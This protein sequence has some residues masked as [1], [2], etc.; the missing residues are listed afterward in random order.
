[1]R[2]PQRIALAAWVA[3]TWLSVMAAPAQ[4][5]FAAGLAA[6]DAGNF[7]EAFVEWWPL[8]ES[9]DSTAQIAIAELY[10]TGKGV[11]ADVAEAM[12][13]YLLAAEAG[14]AVAQLNL[15]DAYARGLGVAADPIEAYVWFSLAAAQGRQ[16]PAMRRREIADT[17]SPAQLTEA[18][19]RLANWRRTMRP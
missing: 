14:D 12:R 16:W 19:V 15:G 7:R 8:A 4:A 17:L 9:G 10:R 2:P 6:Y 1:M 13:W 11:R 5:D 18:E 3:V